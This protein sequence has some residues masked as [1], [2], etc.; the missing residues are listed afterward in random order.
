MSQGLYLACS[1]PTALTLI[2]R[3]RE[4]FHRPDIGAMIQFPGQ[5]FDDR[6][7][8]AAENISRPASLPISNSSDGAPN[9]VF[10]RIHFCWVNPRDGKDRFRR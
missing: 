6:V 3:Q 8:D 5:K 10:T 9:G 4:T 1:E 2:I 7:H